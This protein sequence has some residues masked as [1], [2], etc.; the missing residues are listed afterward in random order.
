MARKE[1]LIEP[2]NASFE[3][4]F[5]VILNTPDKEQEPEIPI[6]KYDTS[7]LQK[8]LNKIHC[9]DCITFMNKLPEKSI[10]VIVTSPP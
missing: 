2:I 1:K 6:K 4:V 3:Q 5:K 8:W 7:D 9:N 10:S